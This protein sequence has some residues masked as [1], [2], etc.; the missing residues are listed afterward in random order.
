VTVI[1]RV[2][3]T[4]LVFT[5]ACRGESQQ[6]QSVDQKQL[7]ALVDSLM[8]VVAKQAGL[9]FKSRPKSAVRTRDQIRAY[10]LAK[11]NQE[12][13]P[14]KLEGLVASYRLLG[15][16]PDSLDVKQLFVDLYTEQIAGF[17]DPDSTTLYAVEGG[18]RTELRLVLA[19]ELVHALQHQYV[20]LDSILHDVHDA[21]RLAA[22]QAVFEGQATLTSLIAL[23]PTQ[24]LLSDDAFWETFKEQLRTQSAGASVFARAPLVIR[25]D[26][27]FPYVQGSE[28]LRWFTQHH[29]GQQP[30]GA[31]LPRSSEQILHPDRYDAHDEPISVRFAGDTVGMIHEDTFGE[32][33]ITLLRSALR[34]DPAVNTDQ[35][36]GWGGD[37]LRVYSSPDGPALVWVT[38]WDEPRFADRFRTQVA[39][40]VAALRRPGYHTTV[41]AIQVGGKAGIRIVV[42]PDGWGQ[43]KA[44]PEVVAQK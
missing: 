26:L 25:E 30:Y 38:V 20:P 2:L 1:R 7:N 24:N 10:L 37:R 13:P 12:L 33:E 8:P 23:L 14:S 35:A 36:M 39:D 31:N 44:I 22:S 4:I 41:E 29:P 34:K 27:T 40:P 16:L 11:L 18:D 21:D 6:A 17:Y 15:M 42:A 32:F 9:K 43:W 3:V 5:M 28:F 19:H